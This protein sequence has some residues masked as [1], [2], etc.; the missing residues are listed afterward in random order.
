MSLA[1][2]LTIPPWAFLSLVM[3]SRLLLDIHLWTIFRL[4]RELNWA[5]DEVLVS[6]YKLL[7]IYSAIFLLDKMGLKVIT[8]IKLVSVPLFFL[9]T[10]MGYLAPA[11][12]VVAFARTKA[13]R[14]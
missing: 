11:A 6:T 4:R 9:I 7:G 8:Y 14:I 1:P 3:V 10:T 13:V 12:Y 2:R 5:R